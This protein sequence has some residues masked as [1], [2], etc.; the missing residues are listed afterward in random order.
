M[1][2]EENAA[3]PSC[4]G[5][6]PANLLV[7]LLALLLAHVLKLDRKV[8]ICPL[9][10]WWNTVK[11]MINELY[12]ETKEN[13]K[14]DLKKVDT[15]CLT[16][17]MWS[18]IDMDGYLCVT[19]HFVM[20]ESKL[21]TVI[22]GVSHFAQSL[23]SILQRLM[24]N[25]GIAEKVNCMVTDNAA[26]MKLSV[27]LLNLRHVPCFA[28]HEFIVKKALDQTLALNEIRNKS[29]QVVGLFRSS[30]KRRTNSLKCK[31]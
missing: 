13:T 8:W 29:R 2:D 30:S 18:S 3:G 7:L 16:T 26:N 17:D 24:E 27:Q 10:G 20:P 9:S 11:T 4:A 28:T 14:E 21:D 19:A 5:A 25:W 22:L 1:E 31:C 12:E 15:V 6:I 23:A